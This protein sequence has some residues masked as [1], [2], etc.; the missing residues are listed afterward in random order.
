[1][2][3]IDKILAHL[4]NTFTLKTMPANVRLRER[5]SQRPV[6]RRL[7][8]WVT[9]TGWVPATGTFLY[10]CRDSEKLVRFNGRNLQFHAL[11]ESIYAHGYELESAVLLLALCVGNRP[12]FDVGSNWGYYSLLLASAD[13]FA[14]PVFAF[15]P[16]PRTF[17]DLTS[18]IQ[19]C[20]MTDRIKALN[21]GIGATDCEMALEE[22][23]LFRTGLARL[24]HSAGGTKIAVKPL[25]ALD[26]PA[27]G[28]VKID[29]E[30][31][32]AEVLAG[33]SRVLEQVRPYVL[34]ENFAE[35]LNPQQTCK[36]LEMLSDLGYRSFAPALLFQ[37]QGHL[38][39]ATYGGNFNGL[40][41]CDA[42]PQLALFDVTTRNRFFLPHQLNLLAAHQSSI[43]A[44]WDAGIVHLNG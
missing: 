6:L 37:N 9:G 29:A 31:M 10:R 16:N 32:E 34:F 4:H 30:G 41:G 20:G 8:R 44:L 28:V 38:I 21:F 24:T 13:E 19:Q 42:K 26:L 17:A 11:Y 12:F 39:P 15:E 5:L 7:S 36:P 3:S 1:M 14:G 23:D 27:P 40:L 35:P 33:S 22:P 2:L 18:V 43:Q 25:D